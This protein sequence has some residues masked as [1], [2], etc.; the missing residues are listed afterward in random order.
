MPVEL[1]TYENEGQAPRT[2]KQ[3]SLNVRDIEVLESIEPYHFPIYTIQINQSDRKK[4]KW[5]VLGESFNIAVDS[6]LTPNQLNPSSSTYIKPQDR[7]DIPAAIGKKVG[8][9]VA[10]G[11]DGRPQPPTLY[12][13]RED[14]PTAA[15]MIYLV[16]GASATGNS[17][18]KDDAIAML[19]GKILSDF[20]SAAMA[21]ARIRSDVE[22]LQAIS[23][24][25]SAEDSFANILVA[26]G[27]FTKDE[28]GVYRK[29]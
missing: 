10:D 4:S 13:G 11:I 21:N 22:L 24:P 25:L 26:T 17:S 18:A 9:V 23:K 28:N 3:I 7:M 14:A 29:V 15:W 19:D 20:N 2:S 8:F 5:G 27:Q 6:A 16:D 1:K 12:N